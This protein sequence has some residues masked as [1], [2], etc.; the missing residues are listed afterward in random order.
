MRN[1]QLQRRVKQPGKSSVFFHLS[2]LMFDGLW[3]FPVY[4][5]STFGLRTPSVP[6]RVPSSLRATH[7]RCSGTHSTPIWVNGLELSFQPALDFL[8][9][10]TSYSSWAGQHHSLWLLRSRVDSAREPASQLG[11]RCTLPGLGRGSCAILLSCLE[12]VKWWHQKP[13]RNLFPQQE[14][15]ES[16]PVGLQQPS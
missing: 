9:D 10:A 7:V 13:V 5:F 11:F 6:R 2:R 3:W 4:A 14:K 12:N 1:P 8:K 15:Q 16:F